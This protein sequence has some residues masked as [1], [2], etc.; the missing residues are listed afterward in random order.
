MTNTKFCVVLLTLVLTVANCIAEE[1]WFPHVASFESSGQVTYAVCDKEMKPFHTPIADEI[2]V[3]DCYDYIDYLTGEKHSIYV[4]NILK[5]EKT[6]A[7][8]IYLY[9]S[10]FFS[11]FIYDEF[12]AFSENLAPVS[13][14]GRFGY[15]DLKGNIVIP[16]QWEWAEHF[17]NGC[18]MVTYQTKDGYEN[19]W[20]N[21]DG[22]I[23][24]LSD[25]ELSSNN[26][27]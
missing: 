19:A 23:V 16:A 14:G 15:I 6:Q 24:S 4:Y 7:I 10:D 9:P 18:A 12:F 5:D 27:R 8:A 2:Y 22:K 1:N 26:E 3:S 11:G 20:I 21:H 25:P 17:Q 13:I